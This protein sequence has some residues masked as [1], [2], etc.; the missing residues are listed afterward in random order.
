M[1]Q[2]SYDLVNVFTLPGDNPYSGNPLAVFYDAEQHVEL[3]QRQL[4]TIATRAFW[5]SNI[6]RV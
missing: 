5:A 3:T 6:C 1:S 2:L 4:Q